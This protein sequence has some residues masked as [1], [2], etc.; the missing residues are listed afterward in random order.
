VIKS[1]IFL[2]NITFTDLIISKSMDEY[3]LYWFLC[4]GAHSPNSNVKIVKVHIKS[5]GA[6]KTS[7]L[8]SFVM[9]PH[10][11]YLYDYLKI[12]RSLA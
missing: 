11:T 10:L 9:S 12:L 7:S 4:N 6:I 1:H 3:S 8:K 5:V 2:I